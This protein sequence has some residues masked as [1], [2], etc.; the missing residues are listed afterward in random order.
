MKDGNRETSSDENYRNIRIRKL[1]VREN[2]NSSVLLFQMTNIVCSRPLTFDEKK[3]D[4]QGCNF[5]NTE[6]LIFKIKTIFYMKCKIKF[7]S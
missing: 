1:L 4:Q 3:N 2:L 7:P 6:I 5:F